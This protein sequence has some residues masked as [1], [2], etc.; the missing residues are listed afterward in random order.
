MEQNNRIKTIDLSA[1]LS[2]GFQRARKKLIE[3]EKKKNGYLII[4]ENG[5]VIKVPASQLS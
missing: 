2:E 3:E 1:K 4:S 5:K